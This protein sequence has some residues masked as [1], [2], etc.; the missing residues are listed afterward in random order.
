MNK[1]LKPTAFTLLIV[2]LFSCSNRNMNPVNIP[3]EAADTEVKN[4]EIKTMT[5]FEFIDSYNKDVFFSDDNLDKEIEIT[6]F[7]IE[8]Y[9]YNQ[10]ESTSMLY[11][12]P[13]DK[14]TSTSPC[15]NSVQEMATKTLNGKPIK[16]IL[17]D[18]GYDIVVY[19]SNPKDLKKLKIFNPSEEFASTNKRIYP[20]I[21]EIQDLKN[22]KCTYKGLNEN[23]NTLVFVDGE[24]LD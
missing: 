19:L 18:K 13:Y 22:I 14:S 4:E 2:L 6:D 24:I 3:E 5:S 7:L 20:E 15:Y 21:S 8:G 16:M 17:M 1:F 12:T 10:R 23:G 11:C 9:K